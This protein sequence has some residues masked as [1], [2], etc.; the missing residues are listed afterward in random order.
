MII[1]EDGHGARNE[2]SWALAGGDTE[3]KPLISGRRIINCME[4]QA[5]NDRPPI[6]HPE[7]FAETITNNDTMHTIFQY[8]EMVA[9]TSQPVLVT[10]ETGVGKELIAQALH[11]LSG[12]EGPFIDV[13][14]AGVDD[15]IFSEIGRAHV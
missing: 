15:N 13:N 3:M 2:K 14:V 11:T 5:P 8:V 6:Q 12:R 1:P 9:E 7:A 4:I 10:G